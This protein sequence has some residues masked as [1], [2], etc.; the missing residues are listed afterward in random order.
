MS[1]SLVPT[2]ID[3]DNGICADLRQRFLD[4]PDSFTSAELLKLKEKD[5]SPRFFVSIV[6]SGLKLTITSMQ[7]LNK[8]RRRSY[9]LQFLKDPAAYAAKAVSNVHSLARGLYTDDVFCT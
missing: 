9:N 7:V 6:S 1:S 4:D 8:D 5:V 2:L 3:A